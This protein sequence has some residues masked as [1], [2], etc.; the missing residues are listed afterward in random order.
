MLE[1]R[2][3]NPIFKERVIVKMGGLHLSMNYLKAIG[4]HMTD[5]GLSEIWKESNLLA[6]GSILKVFDGKAYAKAMRAHK[7]TFQAMW[8]ILMPRLLC[9]VEQKSNELHK[10]LTDDNNNVDNLVAALKDD[11]FATI[12][13]AFVEHES[14]QNNNFKFWWTYLDSVST[15]L[16]FT[17]SLRDGIWQLY[18]H[19]LKNMLPLKER[20]NH[21]N[22]LK[23]VTIFL[24]EMNQLPIGVKLAFESGEFVVKATE[25]TFNQVDADHAQEWI[26]GV[27][28]D[29]GGIIGMTRKENALQ[30]WALSFGWRTEITQKTYAMYGLATSTVARVTNEATTARRRRDNRDEESI[31]SS[32]KYFNVFAPVKYSGIMQNIVTKDVATEDI[33]KFL[34]N[35][36]DDGEKQVLTFVKERLIGD[37]GGVRVSFDEPV[38][39]NTVASMK[40]LYAKPAS[41]KATQTQKKVLK[42]HGNILQRLV[43]AFEAGRKMNLEN[44]LQH[45][46]QE[47][48]LALV[49]PN[50]QLR[51]GNPLDISFLI[52]P[53][54]C[55]VELT[56]LKDEAHLIVA[57]DTITQVIQKNLKTFG[58]LAEN[59]IEDIE[60]LSKN[61]SRI[62]I[63][64]SC[65]DNLLKSQITSQKTKTP[66]RRII[67]NCDV[68]LPKQWQSFI[69]LQDN[70]EDLYTFLSLEITRKQ[71]DGTD[72]VLANG[73]E[74]I[75]SNSN[76][77][78]E[79]LQ[80][81]Y[82]DEVIRLT[83]HA[84]NSRNRIVVVHA[85]DPNIFFLLI[86]HFEKMECK[87]L[88]LRNGSGKKRIYVPIHTICSRLSKSV[89]ANI[90]AFDAIT[91]SRITSYIAGIT[92]NAGWNVYLENASLLSGLSNN[93][94]TDKAIR[95]AEEFVVKLYKLRQ[96]ASNTNSARYILFGAVKSPELLPPTTDA[97]EQHIKRSHY[98]SLIWQNSILPIQPEIVSPLLS[99][100]KFNDEGE[101]VPLLTTLI[102][103]TTS[104]IEMITC[105]CKGQCANLRC[106]C[107]K[108][109]MFCTAMCSCMAACKNSNKKLTTSPS[110]H[111]A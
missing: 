14:S 56:N 100:W 25:G 6:D 4:Q 39:Q 7:L 64:F 10:I 3:A 69:A 45:E 28:K 82:D 78:T 76:I 11:K 2:E 42:S 84:A 18:L 72:L 13:T 67:E 74:I 55:F 5:T 40:A 77:C 106:Q 68:V 19:A 104:C 29:S 35:V 90:L 107:L 46:L 63:V 12:M 49:Q 95:S 103:I 83:H 38:T 96:K 20:Y 32:L 36:A 59:C 87:Q 26:V 53:V 80:C 48:P 44:I 70:K 27:S 79:Q 47:Y 73:K 81:S 30:R 1:L 54:D 102:P 71:F 24:A 60:V 43:M 17:R 92:K 21:R 98:Q 9:F 8:R 52:K 109:K 22:Y 23:S 111:G 89:K 41:E 97:V 99:G 108:N 94:L 37:E 101:I 91:G 86:H 88:W 16:L 51:S 75:S 33:Q 85:Q 65:N 31:L 34:L 62:D 105:G 110:A 58:D 66:I 57:G 50:G 61:F 15:L 93:I